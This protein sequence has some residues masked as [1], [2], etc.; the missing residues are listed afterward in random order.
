MKKKFNARLD[1]DDDRW[2]KKMTPEKKLDQKQEK[3]FDQR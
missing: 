2:S 1:Q 3:K